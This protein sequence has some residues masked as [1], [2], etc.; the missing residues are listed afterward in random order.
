MGT[1]VVSRDFFPV[2]TRVNYFLFKITLNRTVFRCYNFL[3]TES[4]SCIAEHLCNLYSLRNVS[5]S[6]QLPYIY[7]FSRMR[8]PYEDP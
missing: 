3:S 8:G 7:P 5:Q 1:R 6:S 2:D 4:L